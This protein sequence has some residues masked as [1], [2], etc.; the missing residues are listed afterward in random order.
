MIV[1]KSSSVVHERLIGMGV[2]TYL[3]QMI[4][5]LIVATLPYF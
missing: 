4:E 5:V 1:F 2:G 3:L